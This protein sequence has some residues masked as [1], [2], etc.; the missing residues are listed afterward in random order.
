[1]LPV[2]DGQSMG[3]EVKASMVA[4]LRE[5]EWRRDETS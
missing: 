2:R 3:E 4:L 1:V 5:K